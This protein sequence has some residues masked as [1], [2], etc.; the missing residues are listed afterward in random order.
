M[1]KEFLIAGPLRVVFIHVRVPMGGIRNKRIDYTSNFNAFCNSKKSILSITNDDNLCL[2]RLL[3]V[4]IAFIKKDD[5]PAATAYFKAVRQCRNNQR[6][7]RQTYEAQSLC[8]QANVDLAANGGGVDELRQFQHHL[9]EYCIAVFTDRRWRETMFEG[10]VG[11]PNNPRKHIDLLFG[12]NHFNVI[13]SVTGA[14]LDA[15]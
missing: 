7:L 14:N 8:R 12:D 3:V 5:S 6:E 15:L 2:A 10:P 11:T 1:F 9:N 13:T 4:A